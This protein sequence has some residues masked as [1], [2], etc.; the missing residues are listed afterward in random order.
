MTDP[1]CRRY[2]SLLDQPASPPSVTA[3][4]ALVG[5][6]MARIPFENVS[7]IHL[8][9][10]TGA[11]FVP[12][13]A[14]YLDGIERFGFGGTCYANAGHFNTLLRRLGYEADLCGA[15]MDRP[16]V[17]LV[18]RVR[19]DDREWLVDVGYAAPLLRPL[20]L[21]VA[22]DQ[23]VEWGEGSHVLHPRDADGFSRMDQLR[24]GERVHGYT[25][26]P[27]PRRIEE[28][29]DV[30][31]ESY[32]DDALFQN[33]LLVALYAATGGVMIRNR[34]LVATHG[35]NLSVTPLRNDADLVRAVHALAGIDADIVAEVV[36]RLGPLQSPWD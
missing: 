14:G 7:K 29:A 33:T 13:L 34:L 30:I 3:L 11:E 10:T 6:Q 20:P 8:R 24:D 36:A 22:E 4:D 32:R 5:A 9:H 28:F 15:G 35:D 23:V 26:D 31:A 1:L 27:R 18:N 2:L 12:D 16:D 17:H 19:L 25:V 21:Y